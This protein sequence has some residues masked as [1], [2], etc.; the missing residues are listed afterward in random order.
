MGV[1]RRG[2]EVDIPRPGLLLKNKLVVLAHVDRGA[3]V[4][5]KRDITGLNEMKQEE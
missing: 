4:V 1:V 3:A 2:A 5:V